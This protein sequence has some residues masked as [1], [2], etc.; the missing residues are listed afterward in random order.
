MSVGTRF[1]FLQTA[2][3]Y[4]AVHDRLI[5]AVA[6]IRADVILGSFAA[7]Y[8]IPVTVLADAVVVILRG[9]AL[10]HAE[11]AVPRVFAFRAVLR[12]R[13]GASAVAFLVA[14]LTGLLVCLV[15]PWRGTILEAIVP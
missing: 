7:T 15:N 2:F 6:S 11:W 1:P 8:A 12:V 3:R 4:I 14:Q 10:G 5:A 13:S 9:R